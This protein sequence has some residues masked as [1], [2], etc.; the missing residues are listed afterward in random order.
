MNAFDQ[1]VLD[2]GDVFWQNWIVG[3]DWQPSDAHLPWV[4]YA[5]SGGDHSVSLE[6]YFGIAGAVLLLCLILLR[7]DR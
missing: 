5:Q 7:Y 1:A 4:P 6:W 2:S 3:R